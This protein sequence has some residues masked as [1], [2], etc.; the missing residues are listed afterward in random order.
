MPCER[1]DTPQGTVIACSRGRGGQ[2]KCFVCRAPAKYLC[3]GPGL[4]AG[5][6]CDRPMCR[7]HVARKAGDHDYCQDHKPA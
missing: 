5:K 4:H 6:T 2:R 3:D 7:T 1:I